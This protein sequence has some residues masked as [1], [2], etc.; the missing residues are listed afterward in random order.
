VTRY[1]DCNAFCG[2]ELYPLKAYN[3]SKQQHEYIILYMYT[4]ILLYTESN[5][6][7]DGS[8]ADESCDN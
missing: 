5:L 4:Y 6:H 2:R 8:Y 3:E 7:N 1:S